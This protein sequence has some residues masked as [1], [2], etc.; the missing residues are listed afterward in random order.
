MSDCCQPRRRVQ[1]Q[2]GECPGCGVV[3]APVPRATLESLVVPEMRSEIGAVPHQFC[4]TPS[5]DVVYFDA[6]G[7]S[8]FRRSDLAVKVHQKEPGDPDVP[9]CYCFGHTP[10]SIA[11]EIERAGESTAAREIRR[12]LREEGCACERTN[13]QGRCCLGN[14]G[15]LVR[16][17]L[18]ARVNR[19]GR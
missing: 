11:E 12:R 2:R 17:L 6:S 18:Q 4:A 9:V 16:S 19:T 5:C 8:V 1:T 3:G 10:R 7:R 15:A 13:P 14:V